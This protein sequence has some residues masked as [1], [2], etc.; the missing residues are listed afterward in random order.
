MRVR[1]PRRGLGESF[2][3]DPSFPSGASLRA[4]R[5]LLRPA[6]SLAVD[7]CRSWWSRCRSGRDGSRPPGRSAR[8]CRAWWRPSCG[9]CGCGPTRP[10]SS[11]S[12][13]MAR[14][15]FDR[16]RRTPFGLGHIGL[17][18]CAHGIDFFRSRS[19]DT[20]Q[21]KEEPSSPGSPPGREEVSFRT[22]AAPLRAAGGLPDPH[23][24]PISGRR[25]EA[26]HPGY[27]VGGFDVS[28][29]GG[30]VAMAGH[31]LRDVVLQH[32]DHVEEVHP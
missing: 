29:V 20:S 27:Q 3:S 7:P 12:F 17:S 1:S 10:A 18:G 28:G 2:G 25:K 19:R 11:K 32:I 21:S 8:P 31:G 16:S 13:R 23:L 30:E 22:D 24:F 6:G 14:T 9:T 15:V 5:G 26:P 4:L